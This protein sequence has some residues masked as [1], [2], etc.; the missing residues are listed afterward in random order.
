MSEERKLILQMVSDG[1]ISAD[2]AELLLQAIDESE[3]TAQSAATEGARSYERAEG[4]TGAR[5]LADTVERAVRESLRGLDESLRHLEGKVH[6]R[7]EDAERLRSRIEEKMRRAA[8]RAVEKAQQAEERA[9]RHA[10]RAT[11]RAARHAER[12]AEKAKWYRDEPGGAREVFFKAG[13][14]IDKESVEVV[15]SQ[16]LEA[17]PGD[18]L[19]LLNKVGDVR[20]EFYDGNQIEAEIRKTVWG[21]DKA[22]AQERAEATKVRLQRRGSTVVLDVDR[23]TIVGVGFINVQNT[24]IDYTIRVPNGTHLQLANKVGKI[25]VT[26]GSQVG[27]WTLDTKVGNVEVTVAPQAGFRYELTSK[28]GSVFVDLP[29]AQHSGN[30]T[31]GRVGDGSGHIQIHS[32][33][34]DIVIRNEVRG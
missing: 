21:E 17:Q 10:Q 27:N 19:D 5:T 34:G 31:E 33:T 9:A 25:A 3:R 4:T 18:L 8:E 22:D 30:Q 32:K 28:T 2:E 15:E 11:E 26:G 7:H 20:I 13:I 14:C 29:G 24:R 6:R 16:Q 12:A 1:R 23:P